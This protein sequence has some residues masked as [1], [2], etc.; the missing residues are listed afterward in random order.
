MNAQTMIFSAGDVQTQVIGISSSFVTGKVLVADQGC[1][2]D[3]KGS[4]SL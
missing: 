3:L 1:M 4:V 2:G